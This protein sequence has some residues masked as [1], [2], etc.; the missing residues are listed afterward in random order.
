MIRRQKYFN[1]AL[2]SR[3]P[4][5]QLSKIFSVFFYKVILICVNLICTMG[6]EISSNLEDKGIS[7]RKSKSFEVEEGS[8]KR[9]STSNSSSVL[10][11]SIKESFFVTFGEDEDGNSTINEY[12]ILQTLGA[13]SSSIVKLCTVKKNSEQIPFVSLKFLI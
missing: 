5:S 2:L 7:R 8:V 11:Y 13:G 9:R 6:N 12:S 1:D 4:S 3:H 10:R